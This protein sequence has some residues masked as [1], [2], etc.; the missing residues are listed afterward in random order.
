MNYP[1]Y[2]LDLMNIDGHHKQVI[3][4]K[5]FWYEHLKNNALKKDGDI[6]EF[7]VYEGSS[8]IAAALIL[9][10]LKSKKKIYGFD[11]FKGFPQISRFDELKNFKNKNYFSKKFQNQV[12]KFYDFKRTLMNIKKFIP[13]SIGTSGDF[14][15]TSYQNV[16]KKIEFF[17]L[18]NVEL[19][20]GDF[21]KTVPKFFNSKQI[22]VSSCNLD[23]DLYEGYK[24]VLPYIYKY[25]SK[26]GYIFL[27]EYFS[28]NYPGAKI[29]TD[30]FCKTINIKP[31]KHKVRD[32]EFERW[33]ISK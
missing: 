13:G 6:F 11:S 1:E 31:K 28:F 20:K 33:Y 30:N 21:K 9:K 5:R 29:A 14:S 7:G 3:S 18:D 25:L 16:K 4:A 15:K 26:N 19:I 8:L 2:Q 17:N 12:K 24:I 10:K 23:C 27:D 22:K 32:N